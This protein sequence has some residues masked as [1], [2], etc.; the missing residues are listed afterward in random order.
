MFVKSDALFSHNSILASFIFLRYNTKH[1]F[2]YYIMDRLHWN[3]FKCSYFGPSDRRFVKFD[4]IRPFLPSNLIF[5]C[6]SILKPCRTAHKP[7]AKTFVWRQ[8]ECVKC[9][10][11]ALYLLCSQIAEVSNH[12]R[13]AAF[14]CFWKLFEHRA[15][16]KL[17]C[18]STWRSI[19][20][21]FSL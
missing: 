7:K 17:F 14:H 3:C 8:P 12:T 5:R 18:W 21:I 16:P 13:V 2:W 20:R 10:V 19:P 9:P 15:R 11:Q 1:P 4:D 6:Y